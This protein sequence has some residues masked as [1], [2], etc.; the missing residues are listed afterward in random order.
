[1]NFYTIAADFK[2]E[3]IN[4]YARL[5][6]EYENAKVL[7]T[8]GQMTVGN[9]MAGG[10]VHADIPK[11][12]FYDLK[13]YIAYSLS[14]D[15]GFNYSLNGSCMSNKE[16]TKEGLDELKI[17]LKK[18]KSIG[19]KGVTVALPSII[20]V[21]SSLQLGF[22]IKLSIISQV[23]TVNKAIDYKKIGV[24]RIVT[25]ESINRDFN[26][27]RN[28]SRAFG[29]KIEIIVNSMC[30]KDCVY[31]AFHYNQTSHDSVNCSEAGINTYYNHRCMTKKAESPEEW[32]KLCWVRPEDIPFYNEVG[33]H[34]FKLQGR[35]TVHGGN[36]VKAIESYFKQSFSGDLVD[37]F[38][39]F[40]CPY[41][42]KVCLDN[43]KLDGFIDK[44][45]EA[46][47]FC[48]NNCQQCGYCN[49]YAKKIINIDEA[50]EMNEMAKEFYAE[51]DQFSQMLRHCLPE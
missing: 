37:L 39:L 51:F 36:P 14:R 41:S 28:I 11:I 26:K 50:N 20:E 25:D 27:L 40:N 47:D 23:N 32:L 22:E 7:E 18:L 49:G 4:E 17:F 9:T 31:R 24:T 5:N 8:Y 43:R 35:H 44:Y 6:S 3:T 38:E 10:R 2:A 16:F 29:D 1:M 13:H 48:I 30:H 45:Y 34:Y 33:I 12:D 46:G 21:I 19:V 42:F 15:I